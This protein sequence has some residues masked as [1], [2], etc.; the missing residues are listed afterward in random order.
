MGRTTKTDVVLLTINQYSDNTDFSDPDRFGVKSRIRL[1][2]QNR[3]LHNYAVYWSITS[4][5]TTLFL[6]VLIAIMYLLPFW[7]FS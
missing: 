4:T 2:C 3:M 6:V 7:P 5:D 1:L